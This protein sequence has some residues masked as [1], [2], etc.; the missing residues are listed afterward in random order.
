[1][2]ELEYFKRWTSS[3]SLNVSSYKN[4]NYDLKLFSA[5]KETENT[6]KEEY[7]KICEDILIEDMVYIPLFFNK[8]VICHL[9]DIK[10]VK[11]NKNGNLILKEMYKS[12]S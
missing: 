11:V 12:S 9:K 5:I 1:M 10:D 8:D 4:W 7:T 2:D 3:S 6:K